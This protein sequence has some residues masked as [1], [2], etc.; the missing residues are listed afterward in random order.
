MF[1]NL[2]KVIKEL[3]HE[4]KCKPEDNRLSKYNFLLHYLLKFYLVGEF[5]RQFDLVNRDECIKE[6]K[7]EIVDFLNSS[8]GDR[9]AF[10]IPALLDALVL[11]RH[12]CW[13][14]ALV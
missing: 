13:M 11:E 9:K 7:R 14:N 4:R 5:G 2:S 12:E 1:L 3:F 8:R 6:F 10:K